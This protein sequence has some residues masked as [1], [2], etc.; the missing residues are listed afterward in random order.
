MVD[1]IYIDLNVDG[2]AEEAELKRDKSFCIHIR[3]KES[4][5]DF[6]M[7]SPCGVESWWWL[8]SPSQKR[9]W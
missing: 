8:Q 6:E 2:V 9:L 3:G 1:R 4:N 7:I 5:E